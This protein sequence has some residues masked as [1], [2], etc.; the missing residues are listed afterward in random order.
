MMCMMMAMT[1]GAMIAVIV[2]MGTVIPAPVMDV[3]MIPST[4]LM[5]ELTHIRLDASRRN[6]L[7]SSESESGSNANI[8]VVG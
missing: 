8:V 2:M 4:V 3:G 7:Y 1:V 5:I 6:N